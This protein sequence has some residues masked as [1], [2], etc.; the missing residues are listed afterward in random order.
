MARGAVECPKAGA[1]EGRIVKFMCLA[2]LDRGMTP[3]PDAAAQ[4][5]PLGK[6][7]REAG[8]YVDMGQLAAGSESKTV[9]VTD[10]TSKVVDGPPSRDGDGTSS[11]IAY[12]LI[13]C[14][15][16]DDALAWAARIPAATYGSIEVRPTR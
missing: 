8:A 4:Y 1:R 15:S 14:A 7:M 3:G 5:P 2:Y 13:D 11:P 10:G 16:L 6:A 12:F 9:R